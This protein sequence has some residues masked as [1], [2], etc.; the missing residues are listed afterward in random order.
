MIEE[1]LKERADWMWHRGIV[2]IDAES[3]RVYLEIRVEIERFVCRQSVEDATHLV[4]GG[5]VVW[6]RRNIYS[7]CSER[8][9]EV[10]LA[11]V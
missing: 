10:S 11:A 5:C 6:C 4:S 3:M 7:R 2:V 9:M 8:R 1:V